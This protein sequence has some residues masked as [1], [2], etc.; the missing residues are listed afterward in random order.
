[1]ENQKSAIENRKSLGLLLCDDMIFTS[2]IVGTAKDLGMT[3]KPAR[4]AAAL[5]DLAGQETP[6]CVIVDL[7]N[8]ELD[9]ADLIGRLRERCTP[10]PFVAAYG[11]HVDTETLR[12]ARQAGCD[13]VWP[14]SKFV[15]E[16]PQALPGWFQRVHGAG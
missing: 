13:V 9:V 16:L 8:P 15:T 1:M 3:I 5:L 2:R 14:R 10:M 11:S 4:S 12:Q 6:T 7:A